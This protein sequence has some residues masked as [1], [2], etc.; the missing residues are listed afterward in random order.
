M[1]IEPHICG[2]RTNGYGGFTCVVCGMHYEA[3]KDTNSPLCKQ[4]DGE[5][6]QLRVYLSDA[7]LILLDTAWSDFEM[8]E[9]IFYAMPTSM[10]LQ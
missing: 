4:A 1:S 5:C 8:H 9:M 6:I 10:N 2:G 7:Q 3:A